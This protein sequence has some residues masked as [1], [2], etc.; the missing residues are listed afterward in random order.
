MWLDRSY[1][2]IGNATQETAERPADL[3]YWIGYMIC[4]AYYDHAPD[5]KQ[6]LYDLLNIKNMKGFYETSRADEWMA[7]RFRK[8]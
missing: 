4:K 5:K 1:N 6:A 8:M 7:E 2:W 3:G